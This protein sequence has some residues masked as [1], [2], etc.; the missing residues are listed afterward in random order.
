MFLS[1]RVEEISRSQ[2]QRLNSEGLITVDGVVRP[3]HYQ[4]KPGDTV[5]L[6]V[7]PAARIDP[8][9]AQ[10]IALA[11]VYEDDD[12]IVINKQAGIVTHPAQ[13]N[14]EGTLVNAI[15]G[16]GSGL[17]SLGGPERPG[18]VHRLDKDTTGVMVVAKSDAAY[19]GLSEQIK[20]RQVEKTYHAI[21]W[22]NLGAPEQVIDAPLARHPVHRQKIAVAQRGGRPAVTQVFVVDTFDQFDYIRVIPVTG[23]THQIRV[24]MM[25]I[26]HPIL[27]D[28]VYGGRQRKRFSSNARLRR[29][30]DILL[31]VMSRQALHATR[32]RFV[33]PVSGK[34]MDFKTGLPED[35]RAALE[36]LH[37][38]GR[39]KEASS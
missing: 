24:H 33:H 23:R 4:L 8:P 34:P 19:Q 21:V 26:S 3:D 32:L 38:A 11:V 36:I 16:R 1:R 9:R 5:I 17:A 27:G 39:F 2:I 35:M 10:H 37:G 25:H 31:R 20:A 6:R 13:G 15:L 30:V 18:I 22:G 28:S 29:R 12:L 7:P 14:R